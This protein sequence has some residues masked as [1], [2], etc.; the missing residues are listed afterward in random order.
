M[1]IIPCIV[2]FLVLFCSS[3]MALRAF[4][5]VSCRVLG[6]GGCECAPMAFSTLQFCGPAKQAPLKKLKGLPM[7][8]N[9][10]QFSAQHSTIRL[11]SSQSPNDKERK[12]VAVEE[13]GS[14]KD[15]LKIMW[16]SYGILAV[17]TYLGVYIATLG[18]MFVAL[19][20]DIFNAATF[21]LDPAT[22]IEKVGFF[23]LLYTS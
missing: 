1:Q 20:F 6:H 21:G 17:G 16:K 18:S 8:L 2:L 10:N 19:D 22:A 3:T 23:F 4:G 15:K 5:R 13:G 9:N 12:T 11:N 14:L 7:M